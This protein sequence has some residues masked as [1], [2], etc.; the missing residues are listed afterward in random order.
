MRKSFICERTMRRSILFFLLLV[1][2]VGGMSTLAYGQ[3]QTATS[4]GVRL[5]GVAVQGNVT[6]SADQIIANSGLRVDQT[7]YAET[8]QKA[9]KRVYD[10]GLFS[11]VKVLMDRQTADGVY[12]VIQ[13][14]EWPRLGKVLFEGNK[15]IKTSKFKDEL[16]LLPG[17]VLSD[18]DIHQ[19]A[20]KIKSLYKD[21]N[22]LLAQVDTLVQP[23][24][25]RDRYVDL[26]FKINEGKK[27]KIKEITFHGNQA[28]SDGKL[29]HQM[30]KVK[31]QR[32][33]KLFQKVDYSPDNFDTD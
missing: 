18:Y 13:V 22:F 20:K 19:A 12:L 1:G 24:P 29:R 4:Q 25:N 9:I 5:M 23:S 3:G 16:D 27:V 7:L 2:L 31:E 14:K 30:D 11:D 15:K 17:Q 8:I 28:F 6:A 33:W 32:W 10:I 21:K 26:T